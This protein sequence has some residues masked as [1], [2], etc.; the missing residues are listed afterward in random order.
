MVGNEFVL[1]YIY[2]VWCGLAGW[3]RLFEILQRVTAGTHLTLVK[4]AGNGCRRRGD[5]YHPVRRPLLKALWREYRQ[6]SK[7]R[8]ERTSFP[9]TAGLFGKS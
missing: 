8:F 5:Q 7:Q 1:A 2:H 6:T 3:R 4:T 9:P